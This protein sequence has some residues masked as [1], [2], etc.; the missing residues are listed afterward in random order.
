MYFVWV[1]DV[2]FPRFL[3]VVIGVPEKGINTEE[4]EELVT[5]WYKMVGVVW[6]VLDYRVL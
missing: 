3:C 4:L 2:G 5:K 6:G 1:F